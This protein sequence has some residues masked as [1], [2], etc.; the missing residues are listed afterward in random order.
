[1]KRLSSFFAGVVVGAIGLYLLMTYHVIRA[2]DGIHLVPKLTAKL[3]QPYY[4]IRAYSLQ[5]WQQKKPLALAI[6]K[7]N[8]GEVMKDSS[9]ESFKRSAQGLLDQFMAP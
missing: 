2:S 3:D 1:M 6:L 5:D 4:D 8:K 7:A 9:L